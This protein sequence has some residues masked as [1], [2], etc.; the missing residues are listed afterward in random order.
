MVDFGMDQEPSLHMDRRA[1]LHKDHFGIQV[2]MGQ[3]EVQFGLLQYLLG[4]KFLP[5]L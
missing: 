4:Q 5:V 2:V 1:G 3:H